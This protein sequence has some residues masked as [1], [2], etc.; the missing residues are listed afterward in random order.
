VNIHVKRAAGVALVAWMF[1]VAAHASRRPAGAGVEDPLHPPERL[2]QTG[3]Y[4]TGAVGEIDPR[5]RRFSPQYPLW[6]DGLDKR[7]WIY[8]PEGA[9]IDG[10]DEHA[11]DF[12]VGTKIWKEFARGT[13]PIETRLLW[14]ASADGWVFAS[15]VWS[16]DRSD[17]TLA[18]ESGMPGVAEVA[19]GRRH[20]IPSRTDCIA[21][22]GAPGKANPLGFTA[23]QL[24]T[25]RDPGALHGEPLS[26]EMVTNQTL[27]D[28]GLLAGARSDLLSRAPRVRAGNPLTRSVLGYLAA[29]CGMCH[30]GRGEIA[31]LGPV[32]RVEDLVRDGDAVARSLLGQRARWQVPGEADGQSVLVHAGTPERSA[33]YMRMRSRSPSSQMPP[34]GTTV[35]DQAAV[36]AIAR[37]ISTQMERSRE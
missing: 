2:S 37:W 36:D 4:V 12:P 29:N 35:R 33:I 11:W 5:N 19:P 21:C 13:R 22:H 16:A 1:S 17:A 7:R 26:L 24:S 27:I 9:V 6:T 23:L 32:I 34:L 8:L 18:P 28:E 31:A 25:D 20:S 30:N 10:R 3:L 14:K 15:Y